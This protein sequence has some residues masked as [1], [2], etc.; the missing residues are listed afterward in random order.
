MGFLNP[1]NGTEVLYGSSGDV[2]NEIN[3]YAMSSNI[4]H[5]VDE[6][7][8]AGSLIIRS[9]E[10][11]THL[12]NGYLEVVYADQVPVTTVASVPVLLDDIASDI[13]TFY[14]IRANQARMKVMSEEKRAQYYDVYVAEPDGI[15]A[16]L[17]E[18]KLQLAEFSGAYADE[19]K[20][21]REMGQAPI[22]DIDDEK[23]WNPDTRTLDDIDKERNI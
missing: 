3:A 2:R 17:R 21:V 19:V 12:I 16:K 23:N 20:A 7:E 15:L 13:A 14:T 22:F 11:A 10:R 9:L 4:G 6:R 18:R 1:N 5:Y 8:V